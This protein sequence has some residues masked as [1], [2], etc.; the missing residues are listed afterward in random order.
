M[1]NLLQSSCI[2]LNKVLSSDSP[3]NLLSKMMPN[4]KTQTLKKM[5]SAI[6]AFEGRYV[7][8]ALIV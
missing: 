8:M 4:S 5:T 3:I 7:R 6:F 2:M 1:T